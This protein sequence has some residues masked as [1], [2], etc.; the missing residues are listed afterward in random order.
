MLE[1]LAGSRVLIPLRDDLWLMPAALDFVLSS[2]A[3][4]MA[5]PWILRLQ[6]YRDQRA[7]LFPA[8]EV[9]T[10]LLSKLHPSWTG[11]ETFQLVDGLYV[12]RFETSS[13]WLEV[14]SSRD[15]ESDEVLVKLGPCAAE[16][17]VELLR[18]VHAALV[19]LGELAL[20]PLPSSK[21][22]SFSSLEA[23]EKWMDEVGE[24]FPVAA[25]VSV[26]EAVVLGARLSWLDWPS[27]EIFALPPATDSALGSWARISD[28]VC[29]LQTASG[30][31]RLEL[32]PGSSLGK[33]FK[34]R[35]NFLRTEVIPLTVAGSR[36][37]SLRT[38][39]LLSWAR[40]LN[41]NLP[42][43]SEPRSEKP[44]LELLAISRDALDNSV[45][46]Q[47]SSL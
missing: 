38:A 20:L 28:S 15:Q 34:L 7:L 18:H 22:K 5:A 10:A 8:G 45:S 37:P 25:K 44:A 9:M 32:G 35:L 29:R 42:A 39:R 17:L 19:P 24:E 1:L 14:V 23:L 2:D 41:E 26:E 3:R 36:G 31:W 30:I 12:A 11:N 46:G 43:R 33:A 13:A 47:P 40:V 16:Q 4:T 6:P 27:T 21:A